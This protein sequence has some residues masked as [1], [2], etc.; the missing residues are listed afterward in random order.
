MMRYTDWV[1]VITLIVAGTLFLLSVSKVFGRRRRRIAF[2][3][4]ISTAAAVY[5]TCLFWGV[6]SGI[7]YVRPSAGQQ[8]LCDP[9]GNVRFYGWKSTHLYSVCLLLPYGL[10]TVERALQGYP[11]RGLEFYLFG[12]FYI[13]GLVYLRNFETL[14]SWS[15]FHLRLVYRLGLCFSR[16]FD[17]LLARSRPRPG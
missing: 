10:W 15:H 7:V 13:I 2:V 17:S 12:F 8:H 9:G 14:Y 5:T 11:E 1:K 4:F 3:V 6:C 16:C